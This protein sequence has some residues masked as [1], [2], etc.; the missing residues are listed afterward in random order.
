M[1]SRDDS[2]NPANVVQMTGRASQSSL[3]LIDAAWD[4]AWLMIRLSFT[5]DASGIPDR[6]VVPDEEQA[7]MN[8]VSEALI[9]RDSAVAPADLRFWLANEEMA[10]EISHR[11]SDP[12]V[13]SLHFIVANFAN[14]DGIPNGS[15]FIMATV[16]HIIKEPATFELALAEKLNDFSQA[17]VFKNTRSALVINFDFTED[18]IRPAILLRTYRFGRSNSSGGTPTTKIWR[19]NRKLIKWGIQR[20][21]QFVRWFSKHDGTRILFISAQRPQLSGNLLAVQE[22]MRERGLDKKYTLDFIYSPKGNSPIPLR[23]LEVLKLAAADMVIVDDHCPMLGQISFHPTTTLIQAWHAGS[24]FKNIGYSRF[25]KYGSPGLYNL[26]R[27]YTWAIAGSD[28]L[29]EVYAEAFGMEEAAVIPT[30]LPRV[31]LFLDPEQTDRFLGDFRNEYPHLVGKKLV[32]FAPTFR[33]RGQLDAAYDFDQIDFDAL[34]KA[35][36]DDWVVLFRMH[37]FIREAVPIPAKYAHVFYDFSGYADGMQLLHAIDLL[38]T[39]YSSIIYEYSLLNRPMAFYANDYESYQI[40]R[41]FHRPYEETAPGPVCRTMQE[42]ADVIANEGFDFEKLEAFRKEN[43]NHIDR[44]NSD[45]FIDWLI[46][47]LDQSAG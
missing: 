22:R 19:E 26:H 28:H 36:G 46:L 25:G 14:R 45:R 29:V 1:A 24:G 8:Q 39:D 15:W 31:D 16:G 37:P 7:A 23:A 40:I 35:C 10:W 11:E 18:E 21:Y 13:Y 47:G 6:A 42:L 9:K 38:V 44:N 27:K 33:G 2:T 43:F 41:G 12:G 3:V 32:L 17:F 5:V 4:R 30:G 20:I 34:A